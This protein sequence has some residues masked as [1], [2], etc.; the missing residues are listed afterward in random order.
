MPIFKTEILNVL[1]IFIQ[2]LQFFPHTFTPEAHFILPMYLYLHSNGNQNCLCNNILN[3]NNTLALL[4]R[5]REIY[6]SGN[7]N[8]SVR[9]K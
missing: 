7:A 3:I 6:I 9:A 5:M 2:L 1:Q 8:Y 4:S